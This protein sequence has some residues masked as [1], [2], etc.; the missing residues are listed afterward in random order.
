MKSLTIVIFL[1]VVLSSCS[2]RTE[3]EPA[4]VGRSTA[5][6]NFPDIEA[7]ILGPRCA[8]CHA[9]D[10]VA[11][12]EAVVAN[13]GE[14]SRRIQLPAGSRG[15][16]PPGAPLSAADRQALLAWAATGAPKAPGPNRE[17]EPTP[18]APPPPATP[19]PP[20]PFSF[21]EVQSKVFAP[22]CARCHAGMM[23]KYE[24]VKENLD[25]IET[26]ISSGQMPPS[27][28][29]QLTEEERQLVL[30]W[31]AMG[32]PQAGEAASNQ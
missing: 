9:G 3:K 29:P 16:M 27:R 11:S 7:R 2:Y 1:S 28:A 26:M 15:A 14:I 6:L 19:T 31:I 24:S 12:Y 10:L 21:A 30:R 5:N 17:E 13:L 18:T 32:S 20:A 25:A 22:K 23:A 4:P 8:R